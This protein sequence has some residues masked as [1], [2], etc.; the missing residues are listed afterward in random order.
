MTSSR[1][2]EEDQ[3]LEAE[4]PENMD[5]GRLD[6]V[7]AKL[8]N[9]YSRGR[10]QGWIEAGRV[11]VN[12]QPVTKPRTPVL[13]GDQLAVD[14]EPEVD[15][16]VLPQDLPLDIVHA[17]A[18]IAVI[19]K[20]PGLTVHPGAGQADNTLQNALL[21]HFPQTAAVPRAGIVHRLDKDTSGLLIV[22]LTLPAHHKLVD[23]LSQREFRREYD[24]LIQGEFIAGGTIDE[25]I[26]RH[27]RER[28]KMAVIDDGRPAVTHYRVHERFAQ[29]THLRVRLETGRTHQIR[30]HLAHL[31]RPIVGDFLYG[32]PMRG[33]GLPVE[34]REALKAFPRQALHARELGVT[35]PKTGK[36]VQ[37]L[38]EP[39][40]DIQH[41]L[42]LLRA[43]AAATQG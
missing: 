15:T 7:C 30:V 33:A 25:P 23:E 16:R 39:P 27:P 1:P 32:G 12:G 17:D 2:D 13:S 41:L 42:R 18:S 19:N 37:W 4:V 29:H 31:R 20:P 11:R 5:G 35:H 40:E 22:A 38:A 36:P 6:A 34:L 28:L 43:H 24:A 10:L 3:T 26:G 8:F 9:D 14:A 21:H